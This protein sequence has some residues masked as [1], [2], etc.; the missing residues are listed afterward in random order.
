MS[1]VRA[2][3]VDQAAP[4]GALGAAS[5]A[6]CGLP[7]NVL[8][9][10]VAREFV[11]GGAG[12]SS[13]ISRGPSDLMSDAKTQVAFDGPKSTYIGV[14]VASQQRGQPKGKEEVRWKAYIT[15]NGKREDLGTYG[16]EID[17][18]RAYDRRARKLG[19]QVNFPGERKRAS[20]KKASESSESESESEDEGSMDSD[21]SERSGSEG[22]GDS[23]AIEPAAGADRTQITPHNTYRGVLWCR[24]RKCW[25]SE[26]RADHEARKQIGVFKTAE[27]AAR[28]YD[29]QARRLGKPLNFVD[30]SAEP[31]PAASPRPAPPTPSPSSAAAAAA[32]GRTTNFPCIS[33]SSEIFTAFGHYKLHCLRSYVG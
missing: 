26:I 30:G 6:W 21:S 32:A 9:R 3:L 7:R 31:A 16:K 22:G 11:R 18:A 15:V 17:A 2:S 13:C 20:K 23:A 28:A 10:E 29:V 27:L 12:G 1:W 24:V 19:R 14:C 25:F 5:C 33:L 8:N 4:V